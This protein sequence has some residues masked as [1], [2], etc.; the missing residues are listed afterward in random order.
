MKFASS[1]EQ[2]KIKHVVY[3]WDDVEWPVN[4]RP[5]KDAHQ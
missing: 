3:C 4:A 1:S 2:M 5:H